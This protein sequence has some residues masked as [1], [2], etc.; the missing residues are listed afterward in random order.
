MKRKFI[1][2]DKFIKNI[3]LSDFL[4]KQSKIKD[5]IKKQHLNAMQG[6]KF[7]DLYKIKTEFGNC[8]N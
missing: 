1:E 3:A 2:N 8:Q 6:I 4:Y 5:K 7:S